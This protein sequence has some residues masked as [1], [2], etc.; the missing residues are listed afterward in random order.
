[1]KAVQASSFQGNEL[2]WARSVKALYAPVVPTPSS[3]NR[4]V[5]VLQPLAGE[6]IYLRE[7]DVEKYAATIENFWNEVSERLEQM[8]ASVI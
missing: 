4:P 5:P 8:A 1:M 7:G 3:L 2:F 6:D